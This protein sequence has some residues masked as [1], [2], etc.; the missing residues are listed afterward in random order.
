MALAEIDAFTKHWF[1]LLNERDQVKAE[2]LVAKRFEE[3]RASR[4]SKEAA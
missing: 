3:A 1:P 4:S 2:K